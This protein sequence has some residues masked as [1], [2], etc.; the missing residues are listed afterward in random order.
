MQ[1]RRARILA[2]Q[3]LFELVSRPTHAVQDVFDARLTALEEDEER[4]LD[5]RSAD[6]A[7]GLVHGAL[8]EREEIERRLASAAPAFP[9][10][11]IAATDRVMLE[12][13]VYEMA[14]AH[15][16]PVGAIINEAVD[17]A[18]TFGG[19]SSGRFVNG[20]LGT[21]AKGLSVGTAPTSDS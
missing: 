21:I 14:F 6:F 20:V 7:L 8:A 4:P 9:V 12:L 10:E 3:T 1:R 13:A 16:A 15:D 2:F 11:Q 17:I 19:E 18:K 5:R